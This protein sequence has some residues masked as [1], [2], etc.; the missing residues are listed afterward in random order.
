IYVTLASRNETA[1]ERKL[2][3]AGMKIIFLGD[4]DVFPNA[5]NKFKRMINKIHRHLV[6]HKIV[7]REKTN[8]IHTHLNT[9]NYVIT[10]NSKQNKI[11]L[12][13]TVHSE[14]KSAF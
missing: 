1:N 3:Q 5:S 2:I 8:I 9:N 4:E 13:H 6:F 14:V 11:K 7:M 10:I 12:F